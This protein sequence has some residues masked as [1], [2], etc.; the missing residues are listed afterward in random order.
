MGSALG[1]WK[2]T[3]TSI[4]SKGRSNHIE[5]NE[6][7]T[8]NQPDTLNDNFYLLQVS[9]GEHLIDVR[10]FKETLFVAFDLLQIVQGAA[11]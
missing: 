7:V 1:F 5:F 6:P 4:I 10:V 11:A 2:F 9:Q 8:Y 3:T